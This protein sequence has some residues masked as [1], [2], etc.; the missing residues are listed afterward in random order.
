MHKLMFIG[1]KSLQMYRHL[2]SV[3]FFLHMLE[4]LALV[5]LSFVSSAE[6]YGNC[7]CFSTL[8]YLA[9]FII[10]VSERFS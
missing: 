10:T 8:G 4:V 6:D 2:S 3:A 7:F 9:V 5:G 1:N